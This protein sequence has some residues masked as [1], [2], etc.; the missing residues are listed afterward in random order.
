MREIRKKKQPSG[1]ATKA[2]P[3]WELQQSMSSLNDFVKHRKLVHYYYNYCHSK[4]SAL[5]TSAEHVVP[6][7]LC[8]A[9]KVG[10]LLL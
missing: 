4:L 7:L 1:S 10:S 6:K 8:K 5:G 9:Q 3:P 2:I